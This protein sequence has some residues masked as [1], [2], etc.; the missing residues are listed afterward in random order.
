MHADT[1]IDMEDDEDYDI[2]IQMGVNGVRPSHIRTCLAEQ[3][4]FKGDVNSAGGRKELKE[5]LAK[6]CRIEPGGKKVMVMSEGKSVELFNDVW[7][8]AGA[9]Q[10]KVASHFGKGMIDCMTDKVKK[11]DS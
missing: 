8:T 10:Q 4:G 7:R 6:R 9:G 2:L 11:V 5:H 3:S 1:Y